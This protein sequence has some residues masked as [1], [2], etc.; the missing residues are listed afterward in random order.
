MPRPPAPTLLR[1]L[2]APAQPRVNFIH[3]HTIPRLFDECDRIA[4]RSQVDQHEALPADPNGYSH[5]AFTD[6][7]ADPATEAA[8]SARVRPLALPAS[9]ARTCWSG[10]GRRGRAAR[11]PRA[12][13]LERRGRGLAGLICPPEEFRSSTNRCR[14][15]RG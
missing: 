7:D 3:R 11:R 15:M 14:S 12:I 2:P 8:A 13:A 1:F 10:G 9:P 6:S 4:D 5:F